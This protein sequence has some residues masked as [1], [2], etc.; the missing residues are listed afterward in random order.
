[1]THSKVFCIFACVGESSAYDDCG[2]IWGGSCC[3]VSFG[4]GNVIHTVTITRQKIMHMHFL[5][6]K[7]LLALFCLPGLNNTAGFEEC[8]IQWH[9]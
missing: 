4:L 6:F 8:A 2:L 3:V 7:A 1:M 5:F 9:Y